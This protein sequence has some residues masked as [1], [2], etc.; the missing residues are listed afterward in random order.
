M[1][2]I[3]K[4]KMTCLQLTMAVML[5]ML[6]SSIIL[7]PTKLAEVGT[8]SILA[9]LVTISGATTIAYV[10]A[11][12]GMFSKKSGGIGGYAA[13]AFGKSG[14]FIANFSYGVSLIIANL[15]IAISIVGYLMVLFEWNLTPLEMGI[16][17]II[18]IW[19]CSLPNI[20]GAR[21]IGQ[22]SHFSSYGILIPHRDRLELV[23]GRPLHRRLEPAEP[24]ALRRH[25]RRHLH[26]AL[27]LPRP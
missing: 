1:K 3:E 8:M 24:L 21:F 25:L 7:M 26:D 27:G 22:L 18:V 2:T 13:Y 17:S 5:N 11:K 15:T 4:P 6:G 12:C 9:W 20:R 10:F 14:S 19:L 23:L 16:A